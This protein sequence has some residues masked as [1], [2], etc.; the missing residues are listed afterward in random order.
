MEKIFTLILVL[1][2]I[3]SFLGLFFSLFILKRNDLVYKFRLSL[4]DK[5][6]ILG[7]EDIKNGKDYKWRMNE[8]DKVSYDKM[9]YSTKELKPKNF[10]KDLSFLK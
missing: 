6:G 10:Y 5:V 4:L 7:N 8:L 9:L 1:F 2:L 3:I